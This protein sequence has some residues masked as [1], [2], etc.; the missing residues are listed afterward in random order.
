MNRTP[1]RGGSAPRRAGARPGPSRPVPLS[2]SEAAQRLERA[3]ALREAL[4]DAA[5]GG[6]V[7]LVHGAG[8]GLDGFVLEQFDRT[9]ILQLHE[10]RLALDGSTVERLAQLALT[11]RRAAA[12]YRKVFPRDRSFAD[13]D[14]E[15][16]SAQ[17]WLGS[18]AAPEEF[19]VT[20]NGLR[21]LVRPYDGYA[22]GLFLEQRDNRARV[23]ARAAGRR[24]LNA[25]AYTCAFGVAAAAGGAAEVV[26]VDVA[27]KAL[28][29]GRRNY[30]CNSL[31][32]EGQWF[33]AD[34]VFRYYRRAQRQERRF[35]LI[36]L[37]PPTFA[38][39][40][41][42]GST[43]QI[44]SDL[45]RLV[46]GAF[47]RLEAGGVLLLA[48]NDRR[49]SPSRLEHGLIAAAREQGG[50]VEITDR[51]VQPADFPGD[52]EYSKSVWCRWSPGAR[53]RAD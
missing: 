3:L 14:A 26:N 22:T 15:L 40:K 2:A 19:S 1:R 8:D 24:V 25:F 28:E 39:S 4:P 7:R 33:I 6:A 41:Q 45:E 17:P 43:F 30:E 37:D 18:V 38:R 46:S 12:L 13:A 50:R 48:T 21:L 29:W 10:G 34:D 9:L 44:E 52:P 31:S 27:K 49:I 32:V 51:P 20:E 35:D 5:P 47:E 11:R 36:I 42:H 53:R 16:R 23:R